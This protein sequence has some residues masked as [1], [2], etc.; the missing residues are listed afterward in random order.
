M[1]QGAEG[2][3]VAAGEEVFSGVN[4][5][6]HVEEVGGVV[7][8]ARDLG[9]EDVL[10]GGVGVQEEEQE[11]V[12]E[13]GEGVGGGVDGADGDGA[14]GGEINAVEAQCRSHFVSSG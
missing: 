7:G 1:E 6:E 13:G 11:G 5:G 9:A 4:E 14:G 10:R 3:K 2:G 8:G 12:L